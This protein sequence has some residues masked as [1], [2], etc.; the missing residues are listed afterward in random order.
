ML[1]KLQPK[2]TVSNNSI[3]L[4]RVVAIIVVI[5]LHAAAFPYNTPEKVTLEVIVN[6][7]SIG[8][9][10]LMGVPLFVMVTGALLLTPQKA[11][12]PIR[13]FF[14]KRFTRIGL[15]MIFWSIFYFCWAIFVDKKVLSTTDVLQKIF[16][17]GTYYHLW[18]LYLLIALYLLTPLL[19]LAIKKLGK[20]K[21]IALTLLLF[22]LTVLSQVVSVLW[23]LVFAGWVGFYLLG[24]FLRDVKLKRSWLLLACV[25]LGVVVAIVNA[26]LIEANMVD[27]QGFSLNNS[28]S[29]NL[30]VSSAALFL[31]LI[32]VPS[33]KINSRH[34]HVNW[35]VRWISQNTLPIYLIHIAV[36]EALEMALVACNISVNSSNPALFV[37]PLAFITF[38]L[39]AAI[40]Y[41][42]KKV[43]YI[44]KI[45]G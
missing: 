4:T 20:T 33:N 14:K 2:S 29:V 31:F 45:M 38:L 34:Q 28:F 41:S 8:A 30:I 24:S 7:W 23:M 18:F 44:K 36:L 13:V 11:N 6:W 35:T 27:G 9:V 5:I 21:M 22:V 17:T 15:P 42:L 1:P 12:E 37:L 19:R 32:A 10:G 25:I 3:D 26:Y 43:P 16:F 40:I 39:S